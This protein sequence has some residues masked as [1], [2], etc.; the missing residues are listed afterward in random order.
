MLLLYLKAL[1]LALDYAVPSKITVLLREGLL[2]H[3]PRSHPCS[4]GRPKLH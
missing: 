1:R 2:T 4:L 3:R